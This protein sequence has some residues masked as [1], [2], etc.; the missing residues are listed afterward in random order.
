MQL[1]CKCF[2]AICKS[3]EPNVL[4]HGCSGWRLGHRTGSWGSLGVIVLTISLPRNKVEKFVIVLAIC[5]NTKR[6][7]T[8]RKNLYG[9]ERKAA[10]RGQ[11]Q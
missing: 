7:I 2:P 11:I 10:E 9:E 3:N 1:W 4:I 8:M 5:H 6:D